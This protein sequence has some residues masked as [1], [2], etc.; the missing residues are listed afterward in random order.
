MLIYRKLILKNFDKIFRNIFRF[1]KFWENFRL[2]RHNINWDKCKYFFD[3]FE[4][5]FI[6]FWYVIVYRVDGKSKIFFLEIYQICLQ[7]NNECIYIY[8][9]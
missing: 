9:S 6:K 5:I 1:Q 7:N 4:W 3:D 2:N 8:L